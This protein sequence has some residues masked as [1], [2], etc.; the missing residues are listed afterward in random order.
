MPEKSTVIAITPGV[1]LAGAPE[2]GTE[3]ESQGEQEQQWLAK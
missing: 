1:P 2:D 3:A